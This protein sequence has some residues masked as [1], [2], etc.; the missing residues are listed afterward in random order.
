MHSFNNYLI[1]KEY[2][3]FL[4]LK[5]VEF[6]LELFHF[7]GVKGINSKQKILFC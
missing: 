2:F 5:M 1:F 7:I 6:S 4:F 3:N